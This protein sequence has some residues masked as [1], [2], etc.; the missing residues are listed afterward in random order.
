MLRL[1]YNAGFTIVEVIVVMVVLAVI[2]GAIAP[3][4]TSSAGRRARM[5]AQAVERTLTALAMRDA[6]SSQRLALDFDGN[7]LRAVAL[8]ATDDE[9]DALRRWRV[10][11]LIPEARLSELSFAGGAADLNQLSRRS[12]RIELPRVERRPDLDLRFIDTRGV[13]WQVA[14]RS[15]AT[16]AAAGEAVAGAPEPAGIIDLDLAG[17]GRRPW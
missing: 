8:V 3:R 7:A 16:R 13:V 11:P 17:Q 9:P 1:R 14:L 10:D 15:G 2:A 6:L 12:F 5:E 4:L